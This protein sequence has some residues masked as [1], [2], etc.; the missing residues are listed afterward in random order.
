MPIVFVGYVFFEVPLQV[1]S[2]RWLAHAIYLK[3]SNTPLDINNTN[4]RIYTLSMHEMNT[5][6]FGQHDPR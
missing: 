4:K 6:I 2:N 5:G 1:F 3:T